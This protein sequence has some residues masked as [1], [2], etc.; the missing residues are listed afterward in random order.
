MHDAALV[1]QLAEDLLEEE[2]V[3]LGAGED[4]A[5]RRVA[6]AVDVEQVRDELGRC[7]LAERAEENG[8]EVAAAAAPG[9]ARAGQ[10]G[11]RRADE[12]ERAAGSV[13]DLL[14]QVE[15]RRVG[16]VDVVD[17]DDERLALGEHRE[18]RAPGAVQ[19]D[20]ERGRLEPGE[21]LVARVE[22]DRERE[23][24]GR[25]RQI[26]EKLGGE[27]LDPRDADVG[28]VVVR[29][30]GE[31]LQDLGERPVGDAV[32]VGEAAP[33]EDPRALEPRE[34]LAH[35]PALADAG[36]AVD[37]DELRALLGDHALLQREQQV[38]LALA[39]DERCVHPRQP[40]RHRRS[41]SH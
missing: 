13:G 4:R 36:V 17:H 37:R 30:A 41:A 32:A 9:G 11:T 24:S 8:R 12:E 33:D 39:A 34:Q 35:E 15:E 5:A 29:D 40:A 23:R 27:R 3:A 14:E 25:V 7:V 10:R 2:R 21:L 1:D 28:R 19:L 38:E 31:A 18:Q 16:P 20:T 26:G 6:E 22:T